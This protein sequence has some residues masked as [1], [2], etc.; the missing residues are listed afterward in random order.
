MLT[1]SF[2]PFLGHAPLAGIFLLLL[3]GGLGLPFPE[4]A[5][6]IV[7]GY[8]AAS[9]AIPAAAAWLV[10]YAGILTADS[11]LHRL[12]KKF[13]PAIVNHRRFR[14]FLTPERLASLEKRFRRN[15]FLF[16]LLGR[17]LAALRP[18]VFLVSGIMR[19][20]FSA[21]LA[22]DA[23]SGLVSVSV[24]L[25]IGYWG[26]SSLEALKK[27]LSRIEHLAV[28]VLAASV[29]LVVVGRYIGSWLRKGK[30]QGP[31]RKRRF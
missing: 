23:L 28:A 24:M 31:P 5:T 21:F 15:G 14:R 3:L 22:A 18:Q 12:G 17:Y 2:L 19:M 26:G 25:G 9:G 27:D 16:V 8:L 7:T 30:Q 13:G 11:L 6:L 29:L 4:D 10:C 1:E 20:P